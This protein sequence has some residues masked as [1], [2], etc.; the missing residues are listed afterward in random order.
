MDDQDAAAFYMGAAM[1]L[2]LDSDEVDHVL[3]KMGLSV[4]ANSARECRDALAQLYPDRYERGRVLGQRQQ[5]ELD[6][7]DN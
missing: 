4:Q 3:A 5:I 6:A 2:D 7:E 1:F